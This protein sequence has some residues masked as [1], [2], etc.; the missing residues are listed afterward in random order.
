MHPCYLKAA[1]ERNPQ[2]GHR[3]ISSEVTKGEAAS[4]YFGVFD[5]SILQ[6]K[7]DFQY[8]GDG[9]RRPPLDNGECAACRLP[10]LC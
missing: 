8:S 10:I 1:L 2:R 4:I 9:T 7:K 3:R 6:Q 5:E